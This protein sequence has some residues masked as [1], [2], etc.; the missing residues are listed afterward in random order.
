MPVWYA[1][2]MSTTYECKHHGN[3]EHTYGEISHRICGCDGTIHNACRPVPAPEGTP[4]PEGWPIYLAWRTTAA[5]DR[6]VL[7]KYET[8]A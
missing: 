5:A 7:D 2:G 4:R 8:G 1:K 3:A 6:H